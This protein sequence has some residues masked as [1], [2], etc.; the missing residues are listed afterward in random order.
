MRSSGVNT[1]I[2]RYTEAGAKKLR[3]IGIVRIWVAC[4]TGFYSTYTYFKIFI[5]I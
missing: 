5:E 2:A 3:A 1:A 4:N